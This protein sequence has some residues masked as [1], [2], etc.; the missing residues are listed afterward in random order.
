MVAAE[1]TGKRLEFIYDYKGRMISRKVYSG[2][3]GNWTLANTEKYVW[4]GWNQIA[5]Y[6]GNDALQKSMLWSEDI[7]G[8][9]QA[10]G[11]VGGLLAV[12][13][14]I[15]SKT[16]LPCYD[17]NGNVMAYIDSAD[18][19]LAAE[20]EYS[21]SP[22]I[23]SKNGP[24]AD[25]LAAVAS[26]STKPYDKDLDAFLYQF[27]IL[28]YGRWM[29]R[30]PM[31]ESGGANLYGMAGNDAVNKWDYLGLEWNLHR[32]P[33][34]TRA[35]VCSSSNDDTLMELADKVGLAFEGMRGP[36]GWLRHSDGTPVP[37]SE[38][39]ITGKRYTVPNKFV[40]ALG[41]VDG[42]A[43]IALLLHTSLLSLA[44]ADKGVNHQS[45]S[46]SSGDSYAIVRGAVND[47]DVAGYAFFGHGYYKTIPYTVVIPDLEYMKFFGLFQWQKGNEAVDKNDPGL[48]MGPEDIGNSRYKYA[49]G[50]NFHCFSAFQ[51]YRSKSILWYGSYRPIAAIQAPTYLS[52]IE[53]A[54]KND[55]K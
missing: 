52:L 13:A 17:G 12:N 22:A 27:R 4:D 44:L 6:N 16:Y 32:D 30:D 18:G 40:I 29:S 28:K 53:R 43:K 33:N 55:K 42:A 49:V 19:S 37:T 8:G 3:T 15:T 47:R 38:G 48:W 35:D 54:F 39:L 1:K 24:K 36:Q 50:I 31:D 5:V 10:A 26:F 51:N 20:Y 21:P 46:Q 2:S 14:P 9:F 34:K 11:G 45:F 25:E 23:I 41:E 7:N